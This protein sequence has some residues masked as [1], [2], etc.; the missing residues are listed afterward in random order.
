MST[1][2]EH[3]SSPFGS[4][5]EAAGVDDGGEGSQKIEIEAEGHLLSH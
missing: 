4:L 1:N 5:G 2:Q 3:C